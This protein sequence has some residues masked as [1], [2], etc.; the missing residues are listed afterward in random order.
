MSE[1]VAP[2]EREPADQLTVPVRL[3]ARDVVKRSVRAFMAHRCTDLAAALTYYSMLALF[4]AMLALVSV[5]TLLGRGEE[6]RSTLND[7]LEGALPA[8]LAS[9]LRGPVEQVSDVPAAGLGLV[10]GLVLA[11]WAASGYVGAFSRA[12]NTIYGVPEGRPFW[13]L[14]PVMLLTTVIVVVLVAVA[15]TLLTVTG[16]L[17]RAVGDL[18]GLGESA[19]TAWEIAKWPFLAIVVLIIISLLYHVTPNVR[20][21][22]YRWLSVGALV[23]LVVWAAASVGF[24]VYV[25]NFANYDRTYGSLAGIVIFLLWLWL[26]NLALLFGAVLDV[27]IERRRELGE[28]MLAEDAI[29]LHLRDTRT[30]VK[31][32]RKREAA[33][34]RIRLLRERAAERQRDEEA[35]RFRPAERDGQAEAGGDQGHS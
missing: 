10:V 31:A 1:G 35:E 16:P 14:R 17:A 33:R 8:D 27:E 20:P 34:E 26:T 21:V 4:P 29:Q 32:D 11:L 19:V 13:K 18:I 25:A 15:V 22:R 24:G 6:T 30:S 9:D 28:G 2:D 3:P 23:A 7:L 12:M 5:P